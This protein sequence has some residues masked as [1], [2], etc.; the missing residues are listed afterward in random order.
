MAGP[1]PVHVVV[2][3]NTDDRENIVITVD[4][5]SCRVGSGLQ[6]EKGFMKCVVCKKGETKI[7]KAT[8]TLEKNGATLVFKG[9][10]ARVCANCGEEYVDQDIT[11]R[12]L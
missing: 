1:R 10:P 11:A 8:V 4:E 2:A 7:G 5:R 6:K 3:D 9:V 12:L